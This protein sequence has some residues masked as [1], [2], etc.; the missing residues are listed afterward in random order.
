MGA[1]RF[2]RFDVGHD[3]CA[4]KIGTDGLL[5][6]A[7]A[8]VGGAT[9]IL[10]VGTGSGVVALMCAQHNSKAYIDAID[11]DSDAVC[12]AACNAAK[13]PF[14]K[15]VQV[16]AC[17]FK[18]LDGSFLN[19]LRYD[20]IISNPPFFVEQ[21]LSADERR[22]MARNSVSLPFED[23]MQNSSRL[24]RRLGK[25]TLVVPTV[26]AFSI[27]SIAAKY[28]LFLRRRTDVAGT[29]TSGFNRSLMEFVRGEICST[30]REN[31]IIRTASGDYS[32]A[33]KLMMSDF[34]DF[35]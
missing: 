30:I 23:L 7:W 11:I 34:L 4:M 35:N 22:C 9:R 12:Q 16:Y 14:A 18:C 2:K 25:L 24:L 32:Q 19:S 33:Y 17:D 29:P 8:D 15:R 3:K 28:G 13:S 5:L 27:I 6:G 21:V 1:F 20:H 26:S 10:D 31:L